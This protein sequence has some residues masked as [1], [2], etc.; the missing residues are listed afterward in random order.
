M[1][2]DSGNPKSILVVN[3]DI[4]QKKQIEQQFYRTHRLE[5]LGTLASGIAHDLNNIFTPIFGVA[6]LLPLKLSELDEETRELL[7]MLTDTSNRGAQMVQQILT[8]ARGVQGKPIPLQVDYLL[9]E[10]AK[11]ARQTFLPSI[12][13]YTDFPKKKLWKVKGDPTQIHQ[14]FMNLAVNARDAMPSGGILNISAKNCSLDAI[15]ASMNLDAHEGNY[16][17]ITVSD[18][19]IGIP[20][21]QKERIFDPFFTT[22][23][24]GKGTGLGLSTVL[25]IV[26][27]HGGFIEVLS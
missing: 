5:S 2:E 9:L 21:A 25:G 4:T 7:A 1:E 12:E 6:Q 3:T 27:N 18:T 8:F 14:V 16:V 19:G 24:L 20:P 10:V 22:K 15:Y 23:E 26:K 11:I 17:V 13:I